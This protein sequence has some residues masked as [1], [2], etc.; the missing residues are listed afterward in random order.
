MSDHQQDEPVELGIG[1]P[2]AVAIID[3]AR[4]AEDLA[5]DAV[6]ED[7]QD[8][9]TPEDEPAEL[10]DSLRGLIDGLNEEEQATLIGLTWVGRGDYDASEWPE[11]MRLARE[12]NVAGTAAAYLMDTEML[13]DL[14]SEG[15][16]ALGHPAEAEER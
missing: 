12:R 16:A 7:M 9:E 13:G 5:E 2:T 15:L 1:L 10:D 3:A 6:G 14:L 4:A 11:V 8:A